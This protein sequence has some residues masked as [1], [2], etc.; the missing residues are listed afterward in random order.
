MRPFIHTFLLSVASVSLVSCATMTEGAMQDIAFETPGATNAVCDVTIGTDRMRYLVRPPQVLTV[1]KSV[2]DMTVDCTAPGNRKVMKIVKSS[3]A[4]TGFLNT[5]NGAVPGAI[6]DAESG[7][8]FKYPDKISIDFTGVKPVSYAMPAYYNT[9]GLDPDVES[10]DVDN[11][12]PEVPAAP[13]D[14]ALAVR[15]KMAEADAARQAADE[16]AMEA[17][18]QR[19]MESVEGGF[20]GDKGKK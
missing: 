18:K 15:H 17:E 16:A 19:R 11:Y 6:V 20:Y 12:G 2:K 8:M 9:D 7:A 3:A 4:A 14:A 13:G 5:F 10:S 1:S